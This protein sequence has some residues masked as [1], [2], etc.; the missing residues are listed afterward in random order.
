MS[1]YKR[2]SGK[3][4]VLIDLDPDASGKR[5][6]KTLGTFASRKEA[7]R[8]EREALAARDRG[9]D[10][11]PDRVTVAQLLARYL[12]ASTQ[13]CGE[14]TVER[15]G[16]LESQYIRPHLGVIA[17]AKLKAPHILDWQAT[18]L[19]KGG[20]KERALSAKT[21]R[22]AHALLSGALR[23]AMNMQLV[24]Q[25]VA[26][27]VKAPTVARSNAK[28]LSIDEVTR[29][30]AAAA[31][32]RWGPFVALAFALGAR[33]GEL[34]ALS[35]SDVDLDAKTVTIRASYSETRTG[36]SMKGTKTDRIRTV[37]LSRMA[38]EAC[39]RQRAF[40]AAEKLAAGSAYADEDAVFADPLGGRIKPSA[41]TIAHREIARSAGI[42]ST[43][44]HDARHTAATTLL[45]GGVDV[46]TTAGILGHS[47]PNV[48]LATY[49]HLLSDVQR[50][51]ID[52]LGDL[53][54]GKPRRVEGS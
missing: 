43:R 1:V 48:T 46:R 16:E 37:P 33:R 7:E 8:S 45:V 22:H 42:S 9:I 47:N 4:A 28:S 18:L 32:T 38:L 52:R 34:C 12:K 2:K 17:L 40:Q 26:S 36:L 35:W 15:Y 10:L 24:S 51:A 49:A 30:L 44:L 27:I 3:W 11:V 20:R 53:L 19:A 6:R 39:R 13:R 14:K 23:W 21:V 5:R 25:N 41:A 54:E 50:D 29:V 31:D